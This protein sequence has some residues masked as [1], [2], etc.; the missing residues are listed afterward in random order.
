MELFY[1]IYFYNLNPDLPGRRRSKKQKKIKNTMI[2][3]LSNE[4]LDDTF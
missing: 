3:V 2:L 1:D 4:V